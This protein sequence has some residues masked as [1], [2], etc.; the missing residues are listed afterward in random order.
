MPRI[1]VKNLSDKIVQV[2][3]EHTSILDTMQ[4]NQVDWMHA[5]GGK[6]RCTTCKLIVL[7]GEQNITPLSDFEIK[8]KK[9]GA[10]KDGER[11]ACQCR[12]TGNLKIKVPESSKLP[13]MQY[14]DE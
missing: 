10:L 3:D 14:S 4:N 13:H 11:L 9:L 12:A 7:E 6:G 2:T 8:V 5:C 1:I